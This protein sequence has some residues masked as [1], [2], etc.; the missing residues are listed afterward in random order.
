MLHRMRMRG[1]E[2]HTYFGNY[3]SVD[4]WRL[5]PGQ[6]EG[7]PA[8]LVYDPSEPQ[9]RPSYFIL[10][11]WDGGKLV[12]IRDFR[13]ARYAVEGAEMVDMSLDSTR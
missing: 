5:V 3:A 1:G 4:D 6:V 7:R 8:I 11:E 10:L 12:A 2:V 9:R 13:H